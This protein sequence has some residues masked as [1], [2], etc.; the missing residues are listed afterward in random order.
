MFDLDKTLTRRP[1]WL[2]FLIGV[3]ARRPSFWAQFPAILAAAIAYKLGHGSREDVKVRALKTLR[4]ADRAHL[5]AEAAAFAAREIEDGLRPGAI[6]ALAR[7]RA[8]G[9][10]LVLATA[11]ADL[12]AE[13]MGRALGVDAV[14]ATRLEWGP[15]GRL[16][17]RLNG[18]NCYDAAKLDRVKAA[19]TEPPAWAYSDHIS[20]LPLL[21]W[22]ERGGAVNPDPELRRAAARKGFAVID[23]NRSGASPEPH[24]A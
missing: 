8:A 13:A 11:C 15:D 1:T 16:T 19:L 17:G 18:P 6:Q 21:D 2:R 14:I 7:H 12:L 4:W 23:W 20:D 9:D 24:F 22:A 3:N 10:R 5:R